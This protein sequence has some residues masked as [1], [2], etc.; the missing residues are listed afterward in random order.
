MQP[1]TG[2]LNS[3]D[4]VSVVICVTASL[5]A[6]LVMAAAQYCLSHN[7]AQ[8]IFNDL[9]NQKLLNNGLGIIWWSGCYA[10]CLPVSLCVCIF[11]SWLRWPILLGATL[12]AGAYP[13]SL[14]GGFLGWQISAIATVSISFVLLLVTQRLFGEFSAGLSK[15]NISGQI[16]LSD[17]FSLTFLCS[18]VTFAMV[19]M[20]PSDF[21]MPVLGTLYFLLVAAACNSLPIPILAYITLSNS[22]RKHALLILVF[23]LLALATTLLVW[24]EFRDL[25]AFILSQLALCILL[26]ALR[27]RGVRII[28]DG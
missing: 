13:G 24:A 5:A 4:W 10:I 3:R 8:S 7:I 9:S 20:R 19:C 27:F 1:K 6:A 16:P 15:P 17:F 26:V 14:S 21:S 25:L 23:L 11:K 28:A 12:V 22:R 18:I 2:S